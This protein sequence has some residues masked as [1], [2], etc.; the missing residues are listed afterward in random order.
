M[1]EW[2]RGGARWRVVTLAL[3]RGVVEVG[4]CGRRGETVG[5]LVDAGLGSG[6][7]Q[8]LVLTCLTLEDIWLRRKIPYMWY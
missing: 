6:G 1:G 2:G 4:G 8:T 5:W 3:S 7:C